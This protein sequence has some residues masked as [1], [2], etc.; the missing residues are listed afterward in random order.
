MNKICTACSNQLSPKKRKY[1]QCTNKTCK[2]IL[3]YQCDKEIMNPIVAKT[4]Q[5]Y[6]CSTC[7]EGGD[8]IVYKREHITRNRSKSPTV[9][10]I[11]ESDDKKD[12]NLGNVQDNKV[13][14]PLSQ[15]TPPLHASLADELSS[16]EISPLRNESSISLRSDEDVGSVEQSRKSSVE[17]SPGGNRKNIS[18]GK[19]E[20]KSLN[21]ITHSENGIITIPLL[22]L[23]HT[24][25]PSPAE[26]SPKR[27]QN[28]V[29]LGSDG[30]ETFYD[31]NNENQPTSPKSSK[32]NSPKGDE[33]NVSL[34]PVEDRSSIQNITLDSTSKNKV[35]SS[36]SKSVPPRLRGPEITNSTDIPNNKD[37]NAIEESP[38]TSSNKTEDIELDDCRHNRELIIQ[39][40]LMD[41]ESELMRHREILNGKKHE[42]YRLERMLN[43]KEAQLQLLKETLST[44]IDEKLRFKAQLSIREHHIKILENNLDKRKEICPTKTSSTQTEGEQEIKAINTMLK[45][46]IR[47]KD[48]NIMELN[49]DIEL[50]INKNNQLKDQIYAYEYR[51]LRRGNKN[52]S[53][54][55]EKILANKEE[56]INNL[57][58]KLDAINQ[59]TQ[60]QTEDPILSQSPNLH[61]SLFQQNTSYRDAA[62]N[63]TADS[64]NR[65]IHSSEGTAAVSSGVNMSSQTDHTLNYGSRYETRSIADTTGSS[66]NSYS[67]RRGSSS[68]RN[69][70]DTSRPSQNSNNQRRGSSSGDHTRERKEKEEKLR[71]KKNII[72]YGMPETETNRQSMDKFININRFLGNYNFEK[73]DIYSLGRIG[74]VTGSKPRPLKIEFYDI[75][76]KTDIMINAYKLR[77]HR[78]YNIISIQHDLTRQQLGDFFNLKEEA[79][80]LNEQMNQNSN[81]MYRVRGSPDNWKIVKIAKN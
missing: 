57:K 49:N 33:V 27:N 37:R 75:R 79:R 11:A 22:K 18:P 43:L 50:L 51:D 64:T 32:D 1:L 59:I 72:V 17:N 56:K 52:E 78:Q 39:G 4:I 19:E 15:S 48:E 40:K 60:E 12:I 71:K 66:R 9:V 68:S 47:L 26:V 55:Y 20:E 76:T 70:T 54:Y 13:K 35:S 10:H 45:H 36:R 38:N 14:S 46:D 63:R 7:R 29:S 34:R 16:T 8:S 3:H 21:E 31:A 81:Y 25:K 42:C 61:E 5:S 80:M 44:E 58:Q 30:D 67:Q 24:D 77:D 62:M 28:S 2:N 53:E 73:R 69:S 74:D 65:T 23:P 6:Y 41:A